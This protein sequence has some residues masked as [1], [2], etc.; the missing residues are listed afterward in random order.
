MKTFGRCYVRKHRENKGGDKYITLDIS[1]EF[2]I[3]DKMRITSSEPKD[4]LVISGKELIT[5]PGIKA[6]TK[7]KKIQKGKVCHRKYQ[8]EGPFKY[9]Q[10]F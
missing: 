9:S 2:G 5:S 3:L 7:A 6:K 10:G 8:Y 1:L 4:S